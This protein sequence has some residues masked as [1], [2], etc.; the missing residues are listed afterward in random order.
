MV[1]PTQYPVMVIG[2]AEDKVG[3]RSILTN[4]FKSAGGAQATIGIVPC[5]SQEPSVVGNRYTRIFSELKAKSVKVLDIRRPQ[6]CDQDGWLQALDSCTGIFL[7]G[8]DQVR[9]F[10]FI[11]NST[12]ATTLK[13]RLNLGTLVLAGTSAG[14]AVMGEK[15]ISGGSSGES[16]NRGL[17]DL[18][19]GLGFVPEV[20][21]DQ[22]FHNRNRMARLLSAIAANPDKLGIGIDEDTCAAFK[23]DGTFE[24]I[25]KGTVTII[26]PREL[27]HTNYRSSA[28]TSPLSLHDLRVHILSEG[29]EYDYRRRSVCM[30]THGM[31]SHF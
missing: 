26:D 2:G 8:G 4:F 27:T 19:D 25:G 31:V 16:P 22:H 29:D 21:V 20:L 12:F 17:V 1:N 6:E 15:M 28:P 23:G 10:E 13:K 14:A 30:P 7:S 3:P 18:M 11:R 9:L 24:V 5:A